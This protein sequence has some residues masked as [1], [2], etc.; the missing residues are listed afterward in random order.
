M[1]VFE[2]WRGQEKRRE[3]RE[4]ARARWRLILKGE[5]EVGSPMKKKEREFS[6]LKKT[7]KKEGAKEIRKSK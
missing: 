3:E 4:R 6:Q 7:R 5:T 2:G 1:S